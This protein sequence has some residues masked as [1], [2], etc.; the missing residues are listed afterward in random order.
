MPTTP[1]SLLLQ[2][3]NATEETW[4]NFVDLYTPLLFHWALKSGL[5]QHDAAEL[6]QEVFVTLLQALPK[7]EYN[8]QKSFRAWLFTVMRNKWTDL[9]RRRG[10]KEVQS[11]LSGISTPSELVELEE[12]EYRTYLIQRAFQL[13][14]K[15][16]EAT[17]IAAFRA[18]ALEDR[19]A[20]DVAREL[21]ISENAV[22]QARKRVM[23]K[24]RESLDGMWE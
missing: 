19:A 4:K 13:M 5:Q 20:A 17:T 10:A 18:T 9:E 8:Q 22:Y 15:D 21:G 3:R 7:F 11:T 1:V 6:V 24:L 2:L 12:A 23:A 16:F 14:E